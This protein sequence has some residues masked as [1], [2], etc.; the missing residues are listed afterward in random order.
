MLDLY[1]KYPGVLKRMR[2]GP[3]ATELDNLAGDLKRLGYTQ[4]TARRYLSLAAT[5]NRFIDG[6]GYERPDAI[7]PAL[8][9]RFLVG[10]PR[11]EATRTLARTAVNHVLRRVVLLGTLDSV[12]STQDDPDAG[13]LTAFALHL[14]DVRGLQPRSIQGITVLARRMLAWFRESHPGLSL[15]EFRGEDVLAFAAHLTQSGATGTKSGSLSHSRTFFRYLHGQGIVGEDLARF[16]PHVAFWHLA[17]IPKHLTWAEVRAVIDAI[18]PTE[19][20]GRRDRALMLVL[21]TTGLRSQEVR[22]LELRDVRWRTGELHIRRT[23]SR[24]ERVVPLLSEAGRALAEYVLHGRPE[25]AGPIIFLRHVPPIAPLPYSS[26]LAAIV[27]R[28]LLRCGL[29]PPRAGAHL[30]RHSLATRLVQ[31]AQPVKDIAD[32]L[33]H[34]SI[35]TTAIYVKVAVPQLAMIALPFVEVARG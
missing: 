3:L 20:A 33:G 34:R 11:S 16:V 9:E 12:D 6:A 35:D 26:S 30:F 24:R 14:R 7:G 2:R 27:R 32:L 19:P 18:D 8:V 15:A 28:R 25:N 22:L 1:L 10:L 29:R 13:V 4:A 31:Q 17:T 21:A 23:K 5:F